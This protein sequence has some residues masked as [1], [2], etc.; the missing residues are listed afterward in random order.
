MYQR[1]AAMPGL[2]VQG[3]D[4]HIG[5]QITRAEPYLHALDRL[6]D[7]AQ[8]VEDSGIRLHHIDLGGGLGINYNQEMPPHADQLWGQLLA[9]ID[10]RGFGA[11]SLV[12]EPGRSLV[13]NAGVCLTEVLYLK[14]GE[15]KNFCIVDAAMNDLPRP[16]LYQAYH[17]IVP[18][19]TRHDAPEDW[20]VVGPICESGDWIGHDRTLTV[21]S[22]DWLAVLSAG[23]Y[24]M[25]MASNYNTRNRAAEVLVEGGRHHLIRERETV[26]DQMR[27]ERAW[28]GQVNLVATTR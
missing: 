15:Q 21:R 20:E 14:R 18:L 9:K 19:L 26:E 23:A 12:I 4:C 25:S 17:R 7:L 27:L 28:M 2:A 13:G 3:I 5:S 11:C 22:G 8:A 10:A 16:T 6:L 1:A 24:C